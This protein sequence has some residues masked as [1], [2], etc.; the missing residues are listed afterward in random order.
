MENLW[1]G[2]EGEMREIGGDGG[3]DIFPAIGPR[4]EG[5]PL[6]LSGARAAGGEE[7]RNL[8]PRFHTVSRAE[9]GVKKWDEVLC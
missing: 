4:G 6:A 1:A 3:T 2:S 8:G 5:A 7:E 9:T